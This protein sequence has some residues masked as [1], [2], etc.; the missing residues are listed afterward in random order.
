M[1]V[2]DHYNCLMISFGKIVNMPL[3][4]EFFKLAVWIL[5]KCAVRSDTEMQS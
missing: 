5:L 1:F 4:D 3:D 2:L